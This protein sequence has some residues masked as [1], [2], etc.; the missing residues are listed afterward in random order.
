M[1]A[2]PPGDDHGR[3]YRKFRLTLHKF[4]S[5][6]AFLVR[7]RIFPHPLPPIAP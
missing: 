2:V 4:I 3:W 6:I 1:A 5:L 7:L